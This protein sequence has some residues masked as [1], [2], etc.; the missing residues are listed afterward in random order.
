MSQFHADTADVFSR[1]GIDILADIG[2]RN[3]LLSIAQ[4]KFFSDA[5]RETYVVTSDG[6][7]GYPDITV[8]NPETSEAS[9]IECK[10][11]TRNS[12]GG[13]VF[14]TDWNTLQK[15]GSLDYLYVVA[16]ESFCQFCVLFFKGLTTE[17]FR[18]P[19]NGSR[20]RAG[21]L[22]HRTFDRCTVLMGSYAPINS[23]RIAE[24]ES[25]LA[26]GQPP[27]K[28]HRLQSA[29]EFWRTSPDRYEVCLE[30]INC[31]S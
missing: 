8:L 1:H 13:I 25:M 6:R 23:R 10:L 2:R 24:I 14:Q 9:E 3:A 21:M 16:D 11:T 29:L 31:A 20:G 12:H 5:L 27:K 15:K 17:D 22:K 18:V 30:N 7:S 26:V 4:E 19:A 28:T